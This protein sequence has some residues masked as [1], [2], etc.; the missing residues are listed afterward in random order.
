MGFVGQTRYVDFRVVDVSNNPVTTIILSS[1]VVNPA[2]PTPGIVDEYS[3]TQNTIMFERNNVPCSDGLSLTNHQDGRYTLNYTP[4]AI[5]HDY[6]DIWVAAAGIRAL[7]EEEIANASGS[8]SSSNVTALNEDYL[9]PDNLLIRVAHPETFTLFIFNSS[10]WEQ[11]RTDTL[12]A[13]GNTSLDTAGNWVNS[14]VVPDASTYHIVII[15][16]TATQVAFPF[17]V[18]P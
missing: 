7:D 8:S 4:T 1:F 12:N 17:L 18:V 3:P 2:L 13:I 15:S 10:D 9:S 11:G 16:S 6:V 14:I 5:G